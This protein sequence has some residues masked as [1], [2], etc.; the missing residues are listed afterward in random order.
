MNS[1]GGVFLIILMAESVYLYLKSKEYG[2]YRGELAVVVVLL[3]HS[4]T[5]YCCNHIAKGN[6]R[7]KGLH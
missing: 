2:K 1:L 5:I 3:T 6:Q 4:L 7:F